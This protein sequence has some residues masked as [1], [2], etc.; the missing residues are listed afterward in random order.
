MPAFP[1]S[2]GARRWAGRETACGIANTAAHSRSRTSP[3]PRLPRLFHSGL[4]SGTSAETSGLHSSEEDSKRECARL[5]GK[6]ST[7][8]TRAA[9]TCHEYLRRE[10][11]GGRFQ[12]K[13]RES[14]WGRLDRQN[15]QSLPI[16]QRRRRWIPK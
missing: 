14:S 1:E 11:R 8:Q 5:A 15:R 16:S 3:R 9:T 7:S 4:G 6:G 13:I 2:V 10:S 12:L